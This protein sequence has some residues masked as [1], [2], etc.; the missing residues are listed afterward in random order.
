MEKVNILQVSNKRLYLNKIYLFCRLFFITFAYNIIWMNPFLLFM[1]SFVG[2]YTKFICLR[3]CNDGQKNFSNNTIFE[4]K[5]G[6]LYGTTHTPWFPK[7]KN[8]IYAEKEVYDFLNCGA[9][10]GIVSAEFLEENFMIYDEYKQ[11]YRELNKLF[12]TFMES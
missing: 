5:A 3:D 6:Q 12:E 11:S 2:K 10:K 7:Q 1:A 9:Y 8:N 4:F